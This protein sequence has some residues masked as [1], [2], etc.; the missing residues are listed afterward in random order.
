MKNIRKLH[1]NVFSLKEEWS[2][3]P[4]RF[5]KKNSWK[6]FTGKGVVDKKQPA[7]G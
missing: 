3:N 2:L 5:K 1:E 4:P 6:F 7:L